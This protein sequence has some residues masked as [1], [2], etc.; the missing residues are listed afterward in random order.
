MGVEYSIQEVARAAGITSRTLRHYDAIGLLPARR[1]VGSGYRAYASEDLVRLQRILLLRELGLPLADTARVLE[2]D[3]ISALEGHLQYLHTE[4][5]RIARQIASVQR[6]IS[7]LRGKE[8]LM[9][10][11]VFEGFDHTQ[12]KDE[13][14]QKWGEQAYAE[15]DRWWRGLDDGDKRGFMEEHRQIAD[16]WLAARQ[17][18]LAADSPEAARI[19]ARHVRWI[20]R[21]WA[22]RKPSAEALTG[23]AEMYVADERFVVNY[24]GVEGAEYV[25]DGLVAYARTL[26]NGQ[27]AG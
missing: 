10:D 24:G 18:G 7:A 9:P 4:R 21:G 27:H 20:E 1:R 22:G 5:E 25:R 17:D 23:L 19:A 15:G 12:Y 26:T 16:A 3:E 14:E 11:E 13:V 8:E 6:T 2:G